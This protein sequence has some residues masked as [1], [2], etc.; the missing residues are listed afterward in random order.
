MA[1]L[2]MAKERDGDP[3][4]WRLEGEP[5]ADWEVELASG[6]SSARKGLTFSFFGMAASSGCFLGFLVAARSASRSDSSFFSL[7]A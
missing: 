6:P 5:G 2:G 7:N 1:F 3:G 4:G